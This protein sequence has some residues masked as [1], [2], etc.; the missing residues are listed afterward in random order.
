MAA[1]SIWYEEVAVPQR[2]SFGKLMSAMRV[3]EPLD[4]GKKQGRQASADFSGAAP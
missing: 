4:R 2:K 3:L 1:P